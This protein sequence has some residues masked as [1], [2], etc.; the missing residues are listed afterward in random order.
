[1]V[2]YSESQNKIDISGVKLERVIGMEKFVLHLNEV[3]KDSLPYVG[4]KGANLGEMTKA[5][6]SVPQGFCVTISAYQAHL[7]KGTEMDRF[8]TE[9][10]HVHADSLEQIRILGQKIRKS[11]EHLSIPWEVQTAIVE[12]WQHYGMGKAYA[13]RSSATA[14]DLPGAS[15]AGQ[16][17]TYLNVRGLQQLLDSVRRCWASLFTDRAISY[18]A[19]NGFNHRQVFLSVVVQEMVFPAV[20]GIMFTA[21]PI[22]GNR[23][24]TSIDA[25]FG[26]GEALVSGLVSAD[27]YQVKGGQIIQKKISDKKIA[28]YPVPDGGTLTKDL[29]LEQQQ[30]QALSDEQILRLAGLG[31]EIEDHYGTEQDIEWCF[32]NGEF[33]IVQ[34]R[35]ITSLYPLPKITDNRLHAF[36]SMGHQQMMTDAISPLGIS[37]LRT[38]FPLGKS[39]SIGSESSSILEAGG[40]LFFDPTEL[41]F[42]KP[43]K[44]ML[45]RLLRLIDERIGSAIGQ[46]VHLP[47]FKHPADKHVKKAFYRTARTAFRTVLPGL[48]VKDYA[49]ARQDISHFMNQRIQ[50]TERLLFEVSGTERISRLQENLGNLIL[51]VIRKIAPYMFSGLAS[52][53]L[54]ETL[55]RKW[56][57]NDER[58]HILNKSLSGNVTSE[59]GLM[60]GDLADIAREYPQVVEYLQRAEDNTFFDGLC[61]V[62]GGKA[63]VKEFEHFMRQYGMRCP[64]EIDIANTRWRESPTALVPSIISHIHSLAPGEHRDKFLQ[65][66]KEAQEAEKQIISDV[67]RTPGGSFKARIL[68]RLIRNYRNL[69]GLREFPKYTIIRHF[70][71]YKR[72][73]LDEASVLVKHGKLYRESEV[74][75]LSLSE[76]LAVKDGTLDGVIQKLIVHRIG[77]HQGNIKLIPPRVMTSDGE[78][79]TG[80]RR[81]VKAPDGAL[82]GTPVSSGMVEGFAKVVLRPEDAKL[83]SGEIMIAP[84]TDP[85][86]TPLFHSAK[87]LVMEVGGM[88]THGAVVAREYGIPAVASIDNATTILKDGSY[89]RIDGTHGYVQ[90]LEDPT[91]LA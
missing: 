37:I 24:I 47:E 71:I 76:L 82:I 78:V 49:A 52:K 56:L 67:R 9:L 51:S 81:D 38:M 21:D 64:G 66:E 4:G 85:G 20:S 74:F 48:F 29:S 72:A 59:L 45:P 8:L 10:D 70:D 75:Y 42:L 61:Q 55:V 16:Q 83:N 88:M 46:L 79:I 13:V 43:V 41:L 33:Y 80:E 39:G 23:K 26:L 15:F 63:F 58:V 87:G 77:Q 30:S 2:I 32:E 14:E 19:K 7:E 69:A 5:G 53:V 25:S 62:Q 3:D 28:I 50:E 54:T 73:I 6:F 27:L 65:G 89:I 12:A 68:S 11:I 35:P 60:I 1:M 17:E 18:R 36:I 34:S 40:H 91:S 44:R 22:T 84:F 86:W 90:V 31:R 57:G